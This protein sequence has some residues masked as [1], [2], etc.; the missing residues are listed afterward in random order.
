MKNIS[1]KAI[2]LGIVALFILDG[3]G[4]TLLAMALSGEFSTDN[5]REIQSDTTFLI[6]RMFV[7][8]AALVGAGYIVEKIAKK[9]NLI[10]S[11]ILGVISVVL[12]ILV[13]G[14]SY[15]LWYLILSYMYQW[16]SALA[17]GYIVRRK[18]I[19]N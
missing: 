15:P 16:P 11:G 13:L 19:G 6:L 5:I 9:S 7:G 10:N 17:G 1:I 8:A 14:D 3:I 12:T 4:G 2:L 18:S